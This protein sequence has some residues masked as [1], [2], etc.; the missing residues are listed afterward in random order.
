MRPMF[1][2]LAVLVAA[3]AVMVAPV[4]G[5]AAAKPA[6][7]TVVNC[8]NEFDTAKQGQTITITA[9]KDCVHLDVPQPLSLSLQM[10]VCD[11]DGDCY[12]ITWKSGTGVVTYTC[13]GTY[14]SPFRSS[15]LPSKVVYCEYN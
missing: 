3:I 12:W 5:P 2:P 6:N 1:A 4:A 14:W 9:F 7:P 11:E 13:P 10:W 15:R 8:W